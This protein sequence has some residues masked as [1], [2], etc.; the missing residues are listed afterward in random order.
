MRT[1]YWVIGGVVVVGGIAF[2]VMINPPHQ[3][4]APVAH[5]H[6]RPK[7]KPSPTPKSKAPTIPTKAPTI[8]MAGTGAGSATASFQSVVGQAPPLP[9][10]VVSLPWAK[11]TQWAVEPLGM[12]MR[13][14]SLATLWFG[15]KVGTGKWQ[16]IP[17][18]LPGVPSSKLPPAIRESLIMAYSLHLGESGP[19][20]S[21][22][23]IDWQGLQGHVANPN[24]WTLA[25]ASA[26]ASPLFKP[27]VGITLFQKSY[28]GAFSG[29]YGMETAFDA[30]NASNGLHG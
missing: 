4:T 26:N 13:G 20:Q 23:N 3:T 16:W 25:N 28:T 10:Q 7:L 14:N 19:S 17:T 24:G 22:G 2:L 15:Q 21:I 18:A 8:P 30:Q 5:H 9:L 12:N 29:Y 6:Q 27:S 1:R 11:T